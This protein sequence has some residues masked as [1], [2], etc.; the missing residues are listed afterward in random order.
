M[1][2]ASLSTAFAPTTTAIHERRRRRGF[3]SVHCYSPGGGLLG[4]ARLRTC[5]ELVLQRRERP[6]SSPASRSLSP[7]PCAVYLE[8]QGAQHPVKWLLGH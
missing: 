1:G 6:S 4:Q 5:A 3:D 2:P 8:A 7:T